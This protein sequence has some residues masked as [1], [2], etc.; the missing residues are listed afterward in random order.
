MYLRDELDK[1]NIP[2][3]DLSR[4]E[5]I[6]LL[7]KHIYGITPEK[8]S[9]VCGEILSTQTSKCCAGKAVSE[10]IKISFTTPNGEFSFPAAVL[11]PKAVRRPWLFILLNF[12][13][14]IPD[15]YLPAE[16]L[17]DNGFAVARIYYNDVTSDGPEQD[18]LAA[19]YPENG[20]YTWGKLGM[21]A[22]AASRLLDYLLT[23]NRYDGK[24]VAVVGH[25]RLG[26]TAL[27]CGA[28]DERF[29]L[30]CSNDAGCSGD[31]ITRGKKGEHVSDIFQRFPYW[32]CKNY[33]QY[34]G[35]EDAMPFDQHFL[36]SLIAPRLLCIAASENDTWADPESQ[37]L[38]CFAAS[39]SY[40]KL[41]RKGLVT[42]DRYPRPT[43]RLFDGDIGFQLRHGD[44]FLSRTDWQGYMSFWQ[45]KG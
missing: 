23:L 45:R 30:V 16:E 40:R 24:H 15:Q 14:D 29:S 3:F 11:T 32:F 38:S 25:S 44:H 18:G 36:L 10:E 7:E 22:F 19:M 37:F 1:R 43:E 21:W 34:A 35:S 42:P 9:E 4:S 8:P 17:I 28:Q 31:A 5:A 33:G 2:K 6:S 20:A 12:R 41:G 13:P 39:E 26:K 27:W